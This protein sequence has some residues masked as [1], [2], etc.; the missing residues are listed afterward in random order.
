MWKRFLRIEKKRLDTVDGPNYN[1]LKN[2][3]LYKPLLPL[4]V[5]HI[6]I[7]Q[8]DCIAVYSSAGVKGVYQIS[9]NKIL[10]VQE[11]S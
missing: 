5:N 8:G 9:I 2:T 7:E 10:S 1:S 6:G 11:E 3:L 4:S